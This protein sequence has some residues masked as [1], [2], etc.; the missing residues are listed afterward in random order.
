MYLYDSALPQY[1]TPK[2]EAEVVFAE[3][4]MLP[5]FAYLLDAEQFQPVDFPRYSPPC[6]YANQSGWSLECPNS[7]MGKT[8]TRLYLNDYLEKDAVDTRWDYLAYIFNSSELPLLGSVV[9]NQVFLRIWPDCEI[10]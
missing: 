7:A 1:T 10:P 2:W 4:L 6:W 5:A 3:N 9:V 8:P